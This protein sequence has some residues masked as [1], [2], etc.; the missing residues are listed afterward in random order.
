VGG[1]EAPITDA[2]F[3]G[4]ESLRVLAKDT[5]RPFS[6]RRGGLVL[7]EGAGTMILETLEHAKQ[8][9]AKVLAELSGVGMN[10]DAHHLVQPCVKGM[11]NVMELALKNSGLTPS[12]INY[13]NAHGT[14]TKQNDSLE[15]AAIR[16]VFG[17][18][19]DQ[20]L[21]SS[22][23]SMHGHVLGASSVLE[24]IATV[25]AIEAQCAPPTIGFI[26]HDPECDL[27]YVFD[28]ARPQEIQSALSNSFAFGGQNTVLAFS[29]F[30]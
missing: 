30:K 19:A 24:A 28:Q 4:W 15:T 10:S 18:S 1:A 11:V 6:A 20:L 8:R 12:D 3:C 7:G 2:A 27:D 26:E 17:S 13:V 14:G 22:S 29:R 16:E 23:K 21:V 9:G 25:G 5:C